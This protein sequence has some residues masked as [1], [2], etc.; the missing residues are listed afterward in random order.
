MNEYTGTSGDEPQSIYALRGDLQRKDAE[1]AMIAQLLKIREL[2]ITHLETVVRMRENEIASAANLVGLREGRIRELEAQQASRPAPAAIAPPEAA[3][4]D[5]ASLTTEQRILACLETTDGWCTAK[6]ALWLAD[7]ILRGRVANVLEVGIFGGKS[8]IPMALAVQANGGAGRVIGVEPWSA[9]VAVA[10]ATNETN[11]AW[12]SSVDFA[13]IKT[14]F[15]ANAARYGVL[16]LIKI[17][18]TDSETALAIFER[19]GPQFELVHIDGAHSPERALRDAQCW[20]KLVKPGGAIVF[21]DIA[22]P[23]V[24][25]AREFLQG[26]CDVIEEVFENESSVSYGA[27]RAR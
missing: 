22:W 13:Q 9:A 20:L 11:D 23:S 1:L 3:P 8:L 27:Y 26:A 14:R 12:W 10:E 5:W 19:E 16:P 2:T 17:F 4:T 25:A 15:F 21:D 6:K 7:L 18:E 24:K